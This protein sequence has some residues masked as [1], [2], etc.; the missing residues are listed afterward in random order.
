GSEQPYE[1]PREAHGFE[2]QPMEE[3]GEEERTPREGAEAFGDG[4][5]RRR[6]RR[7]GRR[8][9]GREGAPYESGPS[10]D[11]GPSHETGPSYETSPTYEP[12]L[13][14]AVADF[15]RP[16]APHGYSEPMPSEP[17]AEAPHYQPMER[18]APAPEAPRESA[19]MIEEQTPPAAE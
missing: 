18:E 14:N 7:G 3:S 15:D 2:P 6:G 11:I 1:A 19:P 17:H 13:G 10:Y 8:R 5:R 9:R 16:P 12:E 4:R